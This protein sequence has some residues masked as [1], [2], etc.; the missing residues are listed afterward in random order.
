MKILFITQFFHP[1]IQATSK[2][3]TEL[4]EDLAKDYKVKV[5]CGE[6]LVEPQRRKSKTSQKETHNGIEIKRVSTVRMVRKTIFERILNHLSFVL[7][8]TI[9]ALF[10]KNH[11]DIVIFTSDNPLNFIPA[12]FILG[13]PRMYICQD[14]YLEQGL[15]TG[16]FKKG[17]LT[18]LL[19]LCR[20]AS[21][22]ISNKIVAIGERMTLYLVECLGV[23]KEKT[24]TI[25]NWV[26]ID[27][28]EPVDRDNSF[29][30]KY[31]LVDK[32]V[33][34][35]SG[36][37]GVAQDLTLLLKCA[38]DLKEYSDIKVL[39]I[40]EGM[41]L[42]ILKQFARENNL[43]N[44]IFLPYQP[45]E[46]L[47]E[48]FATS[49][50]SVILYN[51]KLAHSMVPSRLYSFMASARPIIAAVDKKC[52]AA[53]IVKKARCG[54]V[55]EIGDGAGLREN[56]LKIYNE[57][58]LIQSLGEKGRDYAVKHFSRSHM[59]KKYK[60]TIEKLLKNL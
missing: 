8:A 17:I 44:V 50:V 30:Q 58:K 22:K 6:P 33:V 59:T 24:T 42:K 2:I 3:F 1:D 46:N 54:F 34:L 32:F 37:L 9:N 11:T 21:Y 51:T 28:I 35:H 18:D 23:P 20:K 60:Y 53:K 52:S 25:T 47:Q 49:S 15:S 26:D 4:C 29:S 38:K 39:I 16:F 36:R 19:H 14:L 55:I 12:F 40:G 56:I 13:K 7:L 48:V 27:K 43:Y 41:R 57:R 5:I 10:I 31:G 45:E